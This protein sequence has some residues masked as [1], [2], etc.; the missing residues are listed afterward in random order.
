MEL[1][2]QR[3]PRREYGQIFCDID[4]ALAQLQQLELLLL[5]SRAQDD[6]NRWLLIDFLLMLGQ[7]ARRPAF[8]PAQFNVKVTLERVVEV[9]RGLGMRP[10]QFSPRCGVNCLDGK[11]LRRAK[12]VALLLLAPPRPYSAVSLRANASISCCPYPA[13]SPRSTSPLSRRPPSQ[14]SSVNFAFTSAA[15]RSLAPAISVLTS[16][17]PTG[18]RK[19]R[20]PKSEERPLPRISHRS[21]EALGRPAP[22]R[23]ASLRMLAMSSTHTSPGRQHRCIAAHLRVRTPAHAQRG[24]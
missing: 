23:C 21:S 14:Y 13:R 22:P 19:P 15:A 7:V 3:F 8:K 10:A 1:G 20:S 12:A 9:H 24:A 6:A 17:W 11:D 5:L 4:A 2:L 16:F 18:K